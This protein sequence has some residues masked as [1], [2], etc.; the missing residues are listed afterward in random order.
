MSKHKEKVKFKMVIL[1][2]GMGVGV[3]GA[4]GMC[5]GEE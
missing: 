3:D 2:E 4:C 1:H 5:G